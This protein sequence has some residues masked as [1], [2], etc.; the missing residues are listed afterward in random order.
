MSFG[1]IEHFATMVSGC[2]SINNKGAL[3]SDGKYAFAVLKLH[4]NDQGLYAGNEGFIDAVK[5]GASNIYEWI[6]KMIRAIR[7][8]LRGNK[9]EEE[10]REMENSVKQVV[11]LGNPSRQAELAKKIDVSKLLLKVRN[12][13]SIAGTERI[14]FETIATEIEEMS[15][16]QRKQVDIYI[17]NIGDDP[18]FKEVVKEEHDLIVNKALTAIKPRLVQLNGL[19]EKMKEADPDGSAGK[20]L[21][22]EP[23]RAFSQFG[24][25]LAKVDN[26]SSNNLTTITNGI[27]RGIVDANKLLKSATD[28]L[29][30][31]NESNKTGSNPVVGKA[32]K[33]VNLLSTFTEVGRKLVGQLTA[34]MERGQ[35]DAIT[36]FISRRWFQA[37]TEFE[38]IK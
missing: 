19:L 18:E 21:N 6:K 30:R 36:V 29:D 5:R 8:W 23:G 12:Y 1:E 37:R 7:D 24:D 14:S 10:V 25:L 27:G 26:V 13:N 2:E 33:I 3:S 11:D 15:P 31:L 38:A 35:Y 17:S 34:I 4:A 20:E 16:E 22:I 32:G 28:K 9:V